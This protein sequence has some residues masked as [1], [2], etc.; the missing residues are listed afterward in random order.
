MA[1]VYNHGGLPP[2]YNQ[3]VA[4]PWYN[5][6]ICIPLI[7]L[8]I[9]AWYNVM[10][11]IAQIEFL[12]GMGIRAYKAQSTSTCTQLYT[13]SSTSYEYKST[14]ASTNMSTS[15]IYGLN[16][17]LVWMGPLWYRPSNGSTFPEGGSD[18]LKNSDKCYGLYG[19]LGWLTYGIGK[20]HDRWLF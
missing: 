12:L 17:S 5:H 9:T 10:S 7:R 8:R 15:L 1:C 6:T 4:T 3:G 16:N 20:V 13:S 14:E 11:T 2:W 18:P 19:V